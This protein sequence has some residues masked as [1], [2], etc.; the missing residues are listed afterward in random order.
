MIYSLIK[1]DDL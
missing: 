1:G